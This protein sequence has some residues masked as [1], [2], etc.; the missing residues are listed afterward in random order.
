MGRELTYILPESYV[1]IF[2]RMLGDMDNKRKSLGIETYGISLA[3]L[4][5]VFMKFVSSLYRSQ[6]V[7][8]LFSFD[9][10]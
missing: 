10:F 1:G 5:E 7:L 3:T 4:E 6:C 2:E 9:V 8:Y